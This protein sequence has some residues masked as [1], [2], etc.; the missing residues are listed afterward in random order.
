M[1]VDDTNEVEEEEVVGAEGEVPKELHGYA[2][3]GRMV[4]VPVASPSPPPLVVVA[5]PATRL[6]DT[7]E[8]EEEEEMDVRYGRARRSGSLVQDVEEGER[9]RCEVVLV[10][11]R[12]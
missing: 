9:F 3:G 7:G 8:E 1:V 12:P 4:V 11:G 10:W 2:P 6:D 5:R